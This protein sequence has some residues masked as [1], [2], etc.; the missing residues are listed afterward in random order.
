M[1]EYQSAGNF[2]RVHGFFHLTTPAE[3]SVNRAVSAI[4][5]KSTCVRVNLFP[6]EELK[7]NIVDRG[8]RDEGQQHRYC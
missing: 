3:T 8:G 4:G 2:A 6:F 1:A 7:R 5:D